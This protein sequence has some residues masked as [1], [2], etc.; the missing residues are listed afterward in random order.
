M[1]RYAGFSA[2]KNVFNFGVSAVAIAGLLSCALGLP[3]HNPSAAYVSGLAAL[4][5]ISAILFFSVMAP[6]LRPH[7]PD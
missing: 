5:L 4:L 2:G 1:K 6:F 3:S 7:A